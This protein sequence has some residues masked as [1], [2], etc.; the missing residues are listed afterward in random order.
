MEGKAGTGAASI[1]GW[2]M[3][4]DHHHIFSKRQR[5][6]EIQLFSDGTISS[7]AKHPLSGRPAED[8]NVFNHKIR[9]FFPLENIV[10]L[11]RSMVVLCLILSGLF[12]I[13]FVSW[14]D[15]V[16]ESGL[17][18]EALDAV[19][20]APFLTPLLLMIVFDTLACRIGTPERM[21]A[22]T[23]SSEKLIFRGKL[24]FQD[25]VNIARSV[26][27]LGGI[28]GTLLALPDDSFFL[29]ILSF[30]ILGGMFY[31]SWQ[32]I[33]WLLSLQKQSDGVQ[34]SCV[35]FFIAATEIQN[36]GQDSGPTLDKKER[37]E[38]G[39]IKE[40][41]GSFENVLQ[42]AEASRDIFSSTSP[43]LIVIAI[44]ATTE[45]LMYIACDNI[46][47]RRKSNARPTLHTFINEYQ[48]KESLDPKTLMRL[49]LI[50]DFRNIAT[51]HFNVDWDDSLMLLRH[52]CQFVEWFAD[53]H[54]KEPTSTG[55]R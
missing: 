27:L 54:A 55:P 23:P 9:Y 43:S 47:I 15:I 3:H 50:R 16:Y 51:H 1:V 49:Q 42:R 29:L 31:A 30:G 22:C 17:T 19:S 25:L 40:K 33:L 20:V 6:Y 18:D 32:G 38:L 24:P 13:N 4:Y 34:M 45:R 44:G 28:C 21:I 36:G 5:K 41:L 39:Q 52:F 2:M 14:A 8:I 48:T 10:P 37:D 26:T 11:Y 46:G 35:Q 53:K 7:M 12:F